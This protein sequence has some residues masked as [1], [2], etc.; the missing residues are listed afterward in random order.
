MKSTLLPAFVLWGEGKHE[1]I[2]MF[3]SLCPQVMA[4]GTPQGILDDVAMVSNVMD[5]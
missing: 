1:L 5:Q 3:V 2:F 4:H